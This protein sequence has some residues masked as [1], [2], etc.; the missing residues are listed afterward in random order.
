MPWPIS[1]RV[2][3]H[4]NGR[5]VSVAVP[6]GEQQDRECPALHFLPQDRGDLPADEFAVV[7]A[8]D[9][10]RC[11]HAAILRVLRSDGGVVAGRARPL[12]QVR[13]TVMDSPM[14][15]ESGTKS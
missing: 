7:L 9:C 14:S 5:G 15:L 2:G 13:R 3:E 10:G 8:L 11:A 4:G 1:L 6:A 12:A